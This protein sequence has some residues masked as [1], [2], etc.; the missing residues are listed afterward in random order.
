MNNKV[1]RVLGCGTRDFD[2]D[3][4]LCNESGVTEQMFAYLDKNIYTEILQ[5][6]YSNFEIQIVEGYA[7]GADKYFRGFANRHNMM[8]AHFP[9]AWDKY[10]KSAGYRRNAEM[11]EHIKEADSRYAV[12]LWDG[13]SRGTR[14]TIDMCI[15]E[16][17]PAYVFLYN[18]RRWI[19]D[20]NELILYLRTV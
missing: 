19:K 11:I 5:Y 16:N 17:I 7:R 8:C 10:G 3:G 9:A 15:K 6:E 12:C 20:Q 4:Y 2:E 18:E 14:S 1:L 13:T